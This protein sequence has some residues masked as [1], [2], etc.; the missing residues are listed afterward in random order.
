M[1]LIGIKTFD[2]D[3]EEYDDDN[4]DG[5][6]DD[7]DEDNDVDNDDDVAPYNQYYSEQSRAAQ[8]IITLVT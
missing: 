7:K 4:D 8:V 3:N 5:N 1:I 2:D 6:D